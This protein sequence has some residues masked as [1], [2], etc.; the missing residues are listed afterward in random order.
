MNQEAVEMVPQEHLRYLEQQ[1]G[2]GVWEWVLE[3]DRLLWS[4]GLFRILGLSPEAVSPSFELYRSVVHPDDQVDFTDKHAVATTGKLAHRR[5]RIIRPT[6][7][8]R[9]IESHGQLLF[10]NDGQPRRM[11]GFARDVTDIKAAMDT[12]AAHSSVMRAIRELTG[13]RIWRTSQD[14]TV[15]DDASWWQTVDRSHSPVHSSSRH[16]NIHPEDVSAEGIAWAHATETSTV[17]RSTFRVKYPTGSYGHVSSVAL[18]VRSDIGEALGWVGV[19]LAA[20][21]SA[22]VRYLN[23]DEVPPALFRAARGYLDLPGEAF[24]AEVGVSYST[25]RRIEGASS[26]ASKVGLVTRQHIVDF[27]AQRRVRFTAD[28]SGTP[29]LSITRV[30]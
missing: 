7:E 14:G 8:L 23:A 5:F 26:G 1:L 19:T 15:V 22:P 9:W 4:D 12:S 25:I 2:I 10:D 6:G 30:D 24:A 27:L 28:A 21:I 16:E 17:Y 11:I 18:P 29:Q 20:D 3:A 13:A